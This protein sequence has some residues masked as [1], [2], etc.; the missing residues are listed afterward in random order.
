MTRLWSL[1]LVLLLAPPALAAGSQ[2]EGAPGLKPAALSDKEAFML[3]FGKG[4]GA[5]RIL[6][7]LQRDGLISAATRRRYAERLEQLLSESGDSATDRRN[8][9]I[10]MA[11]ADGRPSLCPE[12]LLPQNPR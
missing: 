2:P 8:A 4:N 11:F 12:R 10:G 6:C 1:V 9:R 7:A 3:M 5:M